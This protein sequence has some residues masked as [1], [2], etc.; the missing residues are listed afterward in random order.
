MGFQGVVVYQG[1]DHALSGDAE[2]GCIGG[3]ADRF[4]QG[5][6]FDQEGGQGGDE[7]ICTAGG[8]YGNKFGGRKVFRGFRGFQVAAFVSKGYD[9]SLDPFLKKVFG[10]FFYSSVLGAQGGS[11]FSVGDENIRVLKKLLGDGF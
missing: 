1:G 7:G 10:L 2:A 4:F 5:V 11:F 6:A 9:D 8:V 3:Y